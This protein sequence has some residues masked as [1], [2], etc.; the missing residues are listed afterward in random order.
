MKFYVQLAGLTLLG[1]IGIGMVLWGYF[2]STPKVILPVSSVKDGY[3]SC[4]QKV[5]DEV[6]GECLEE[7]TVVAYDQYPI[8]EI[9]AVLD[10]LEYRQK[11]RWCHEVMHYFGWRAYEEAP[12]IAEAFIRSSGFCDSG[13]YHG[14]IEEYLRNEGFSGNIK[15]LVRN[16]CTDSLAGR[17][18]LS[19]GH[20][21]LC[22]HGLGHGLMFVTSSDLRKSLE[23]CDELD[24]D[25][26][27]GCYS[28]AF[29]EF[30]A[31]KA[32]GP[33]GN[34]REWADFSHCPT[35]ND[36]HLWMCYHRQGI[37]NLAAAGGDV[38]EAMELCLQLPEEYW[39]GCFLGVGANNP[40]PNRSHAESG[41]A[42]NAALAVSEEAYLNCLDGS[43]GFVMQIEW[44]DMQGALEFCS[45]TDPAYMQSC[46]TYSGKAVTSWIKDSETIEG[47]C[48][49]FQTEEAQAACIQG[50]T[51]L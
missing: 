11:D 8:D 1:L 51:G 23:L 49:A 29:M 19:D 50:G 22:Y 7:L 45:E 43:L 42:C 3:I 30:T 34:Q 20:I 46:Y 10:T 13:M 12:D 33:L 31:S 15:E 14:V 39:N 41:R 16:S 2:A 48:A 17:T 35:L 38:K 40:A 18:D 28:G 21:G 25:A 4:I 9:A 47:K 44:G 37:N 36:E 27:G 6:I 32:F 24:A 26:A 5:D